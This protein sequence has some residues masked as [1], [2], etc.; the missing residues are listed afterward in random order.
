M[1]RALALDKQ[2]PC[3]FSRVRYGSGGGGQLWRWQL[4]CLKWSIVIYPILPALL[5]MGRPWV[6]D[7]DD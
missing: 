4:M 2:V 7:A 6:G 1:Q 3:Y 5:L